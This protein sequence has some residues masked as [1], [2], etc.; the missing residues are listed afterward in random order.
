MSIE[1]RIKYAEARR[2]EAISNGTV[3]DIVYWNGYVDGLKA[4]KRD[5]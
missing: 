4:V 5:G 3:N 1:E 2:D